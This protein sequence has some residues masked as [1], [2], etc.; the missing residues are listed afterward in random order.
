[1]SD[2]TYKIPDSTN[3]IR[4]LIAHLKRAGEDKL[5]ELLSSA[6]CSISNTGLFS[7]QRWNANRTEVI[8]HIPKSK[9]DKLDDYISKDVRLTL[10]G[11]CDKVMPKDAG[12]DVMEV[13]FVL[14]FDIDESQKDL[15]EDLRSIESTLEKTISSFTLPRDV[16]NK[17]KEMAE[18]YLYLYAV[19]NYMRIFIEKV[20]DKNY[21][22]DYFSKLTIP[23]NVHDNIEKRKMQ[24]STNRWL[25]V[26]GNS[27]LFYLDFKE[28]GTLIQNNWAI[29][30]DYFPDQSWINS[31]MDELGNCRNLVAHN[32]YIGDHE[33]DVIRVN[34][35]S[36][37]R[38]LNEFMTS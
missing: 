36:I 25:R 15:E 14:E 33:R 31:K 18:V 37:V 28:L 21:G 13:E 16:L 32:S 11:C 34:F 26:R 20:A 5:V 7:G 17:G 3:Y 12:L 6:K 9:Y 10:I 4:A 35:N 19:E 29:F 30:K 8:F 23:R 24:E 1:M 27:E 38:Q 2:F 22:S